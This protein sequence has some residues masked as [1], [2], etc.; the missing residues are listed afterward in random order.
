MRRY[1]DISLALYLLQVRHGE[2]VSEKVRGHIDVF[3]AAAHLSV[4]E[5]IGHFEDDLDDKEL[6]NEVG[7]PRWSC[8]MESAVEILTRLQCL[9]YTSVVGNW[10]VLPSL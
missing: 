3:L 4:H 2:V 6:L 5:T 10:N 9:Y 1:A 7:S 8:I